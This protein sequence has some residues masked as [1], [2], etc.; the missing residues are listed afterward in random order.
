MD[1]SGRDLVRLDGLD[2][3]FEADVDVDVEGCSSR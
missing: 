2:R 1:D 3:E